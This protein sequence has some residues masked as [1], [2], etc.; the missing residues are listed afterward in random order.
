[1]KAQTDSVPGHGL[2]TIRRLMTTA[3]LAGG[4]AACGGSSQPQISV[5]PSKPDGVYVIQDGRLGR[6][7]EDSQKVLKTWDQRTNLKENL[8][9][10][11][12][13]PS[14]A[15][16]AP[17]AD[18]ILL[19]KVARV[20]N[21]VDKSGAVRNAPKAEWVSANVP[22]YMVPV[23]VKRSSDNPQVL[24]VT[25]NEPLEPG[26][27]SL[28]Y[29]TDK[30]R[31]GGRFGIGWSAIDKA[32]Y[33][34]RHCVDR[35]MTKPAVYRP[36]A[37]RDA[38]ENAV[39]KVHGLQVRKQI[40]GGKPT[41]V[42]EGRLTNSSAQQQKVP[43][44]LAVI[45]DK[46]GRELSRW[47]FQPKVTL[48]RPGATLSFRTGTQTPPKGTAGV[49]VLLLDEEAARQQSFLQDTEMPAP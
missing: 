6:L 46:S 45:N 37:E 13:H 20:R 9:F 25:A 38:V 15:A 43:A 10:L 36:C 34:S 23:T 2:C 39:L 16:A 17:D 31:V 29:R 7:D 41:L 3:L 1:M 30:Q 24:L 49:A 14:V 18:R 35:Y 12:I 8:Q 32:Q 48:L 21:N 42:L 27:Y 44:L 26:L 47:T 4:L 40:V 11:V 33:A 5:D 19:Q 28:T 22:A